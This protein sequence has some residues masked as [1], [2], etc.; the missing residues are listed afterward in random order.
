MPVALRQ[1]L[2]LMPRD[3]D[4]KFTLFK[5]KMASVGDYLV[6]TFDAQILFLPM[7]VAEN[8]RD[9]LTCREIRDMMERKKRSAFVR[10]RLKSF[11]SYRPDRSGGSDHF[12]AP[13]CTHFVLQHEYPYDWNIIYG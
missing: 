2:N 9:D 1:K 3:F 10:T 11:G 8:Q 5:R 6:N 4:K 7:D 12:A 13:S